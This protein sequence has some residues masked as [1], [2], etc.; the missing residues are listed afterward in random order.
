VAKRIFLIGSLILAI[1]LVVFAGWWVNRATPSSQA[2]ASSARSTTSANGAGSKVMEA[3]RAVAGSL[4]WRVVSSYTAR[5]IKNEYLPFTA[6][7]IYLIMDVAAT[8]EGSQPVTVIGNHIKLRVGQV[9]F[10]LNANGLAGLELSGHK[11]ISGIDLGPA[12]TATG[13]VVFDVPKTTVTATSELCL[14]GQTC[15]PQGE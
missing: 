12:R 5:Q 13:W 7:G 1:D 9:E 14:D 3:P 6:K 2:R 8:N 4:S 10:P 15:L 11:P